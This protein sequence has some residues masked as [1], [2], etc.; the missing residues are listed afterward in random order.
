MTQD[1][2]QVRVVWLSLLR[3]LD[4][5]LVDTNETTVLWAK[6]WRG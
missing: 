1:F 2:S 4:D 5:A 3:L 6:T